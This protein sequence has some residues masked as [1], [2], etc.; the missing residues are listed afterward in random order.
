MTRL[1]VLVAFLVSWSLGVAQDLVITNARIIDGAGATIEQGSLV[2]R[3]GRIV[4]VSGSAPQAQGSMEIDAQGMTV[5]PGM[6]DTHRHLLTNTGIGN[7]EDLDQWIEDQ[8]PQVLEGLLAGGLT[9]VMS[10]ADLFPNIL[11]VRARIA[12]GELLGPRV[13]TA[14]RCFSSPNDHPSATVCHGDP[15]CRSRLVWEVTDPDVAR[16]KVRELADAGVDAVKAVYDSVT[17]EE[18]RLSDTVLAAIIEEA[19]AQGLPATVHATTVDDLLK[20]VDL[21]QIGG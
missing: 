17:V 21:V 7:A 6:I 1:L 19:K 10:A 20:V 2:V 16:T 4:S 3:N 5:M 8:I 15:F 14:G 9:T 13:L 18:T 12:A 11:D